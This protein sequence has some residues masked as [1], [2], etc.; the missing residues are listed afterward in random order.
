MVGLYIVAKKILIL[1]THFK[2]LFTKV[3]IGGVKKTIGYPLIFE[4]TDLR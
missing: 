3:Y 2:L 1:F 4:T